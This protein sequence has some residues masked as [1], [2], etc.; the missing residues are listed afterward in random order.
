MREHKEILWQD[1]YGACDI[2]DNDG[3]IEIHQSELTEG[4][5]SIIIEK[6]ALHALITILKQYAR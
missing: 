2:Y 4:E 5:N 1:W 6:H 3:S